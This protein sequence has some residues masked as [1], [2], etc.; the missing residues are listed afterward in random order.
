MENASYYR[1]KLLSLILRHASGCW[2]WQGGTNAA[3]YG[4]LRVN[5]TSKG[6]HVVSW[7]LH[8][9]PVNGK[10]VLHRCDVRACCNPDHLWLG[11][12]REN[13][14]DAIRKGRHRAA[15]KRSNV[16]VRRF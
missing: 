14:E 3:G 11:T 16:F 9:G 13:V 5:G 7:L 8:R 1:D 10:Y 6:A 4:M 15:R 2:L 12:Q